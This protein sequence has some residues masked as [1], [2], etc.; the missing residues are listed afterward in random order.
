MIKY[1]VKKGI[2]NLSNGLNILNEL[3]YPK[4]LLNIV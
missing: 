3:N 4:E 2:T 1:K